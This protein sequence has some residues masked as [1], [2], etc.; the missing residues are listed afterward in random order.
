MGLR[1]SHK[2]SL[3][4]TKKPR[5][6]AYEYKFDRFCCISVVLSASLRP[7]TRDMSAPTVTTL[8]LPDEV[9]SAKQAG[10]RYVIPK[11]RGIRLIR[12]GESF[13]YIDPDDN[14]VNDPET[15][16]RIKSLV[17]PPAWS[18]VWISPRADGHIQAVGWDA[19][20]RKQY[21]YHP[22]YRAA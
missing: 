15:P 11:G 10:L 19:K 20:G 8:P 12:A 16:S 5:R 21:R 7:T 17:I 4:R 1:T 22:E 14:P 13:R 18:S 6:S 2:A 9:E 3:S